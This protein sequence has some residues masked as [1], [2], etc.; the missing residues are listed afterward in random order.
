MTSRAEVVAAA[1]GWLGTPYRHQASLKGVG[2]DCL[3]LLRGVWREVQ[4]PEPEAPPPYA[5]DGASLRSGMTLQLAAERHLLRVQHSA[6]DA[7]D[8]LLFRWRQ[9]L[10]PAHVGIATG[11]STMVHAQD[12]HAVS[13]ISLN[14]WWLRHLAGVYC[15]PTVR[16]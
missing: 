13:E 15:F 14:G 4:G 1:R 12:G 11:A 16:M 8:V 7:G 2:C 9:H 10:A 6:F 5:A 3:G